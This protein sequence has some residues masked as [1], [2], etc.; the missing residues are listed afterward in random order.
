MGNKQTPTH[1]QTI[2]AA[3]QA[4]AQET[5]QAA[6]LRAQDIKAALPY[7]TKVPPEAWDWTIEQIRGGDT[8]ANIIRSLED[9]LSI[10]LS[11]GVIALK[12]RQDPEFAARYLEALED[13]FVTIAQETRDVAR[14]VEGFS[15]GDVQRDRLI[16]ETDLKLAAKF[17]RKLLGDKLDVDVRS[18]NIVLRGDSDDVC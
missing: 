13:A 10:T 3:L 14:G 9:K 18:V 16:V 6:Q 5:A 1:G 8:D 11:R 4:K 15:S 2:S 12:R 7:V 17:A